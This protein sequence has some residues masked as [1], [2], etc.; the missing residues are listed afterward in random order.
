[1]KNRQSS[2]STDIA[3]L[4]DK[5]L[6]RSEKFLNKKR[7]KNRRGGLLSTK[8]QKGRD[9]ASKSEANSQHVATNKRKKQKN[10]NQQK[11]AKTVHNITQSTPKVKLRKSNQLRSSSIKTRAKQRTFNQQN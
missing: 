11:L 7:Q 10:R 8:K 2:K 1:M 3:H 5:Q 4:K 6:K 9:S